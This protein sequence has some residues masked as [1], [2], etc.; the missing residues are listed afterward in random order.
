MQ[1]L[2]SEVYSVPNAGAVGEYFAP[3]IFSRPPTRAV[4]H[5]LG[6][7]LRTDERRR[8][9]YALSATL[10]AKHRDFDEVFKKE[11]QP[12]EPPFARSH[13]LSVPQCG[14]R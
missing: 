2:R 9:Q 7:F 3:S 11:Q 10:T 5:P 12:R 8:R 1:P 6:T 4:P 14:A 13:R